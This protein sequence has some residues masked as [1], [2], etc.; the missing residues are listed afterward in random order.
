MRGW[1]KRQAVLLV[2]GLGLLGAPGRA[3]AQAP[4]DGEAPA[5]SP[6]EAPAPLE[7]ETPAPSPDELPAHADGMPQVNPD[8]RGSED[9]AGSIKERAAYCLVMDRHFVSAR[10]LA[11]E[12]L[13]QHPDSFRA[14]FVM[15]YAQHFGEA[16]LP[17]ALFHLEAA[18]RGFVRAWGIEPDKEAS[19]WQ[20]YYRILLELLYV[21][22]EMDHHEAKILYVDRLRERLGISYEARKAWP[23]LKLKRFDEARRIAKKAAESEDEWERAVGLTGLCAVESELRNREAAYEACKDAARRVMRTDSDG[24]VELSNAAAAAEEMFAFDEAERL[25]LQA[26]QR[27]PEGSVNPWGRLVRLYLRQGRLAEAL[28]AWRQM[29]TYRAGRVGAHM[30]QQDQAEAD[31]IGAAVMLVAGRGEDAERITRRT[32]SRPDRQGTSSAASDQNEAGADIMDRVAKQTAARSLEARASIVG[33]GESLKL[34]A[35]AWELRYEAWQSGRRAADV[36]A[37]EERLLSTLRPECPGS[38]ELPSWLDAEVIDLVGPGVA[39]AALKTSRRQETLPEALSEPVFLGFEA[40]A[41]WRR[42]DMERALTLAQEVLRLLPASEALHRARAAAVGAAA[43]AELGQQSQAR[44]LYQVVIAQD[45]AVIRRLG[46]RLPVRL[47]GLGNAQVVADALDLLEGS[48]A[49]DIVDWGLVLQVGLQEVRLVT[50][51]GSVVSSLEVPPRP[52]GKDAPDL[53]EAQWLANSVHEG[54]LAPNLDITQSDVRSLDGSLG[55]GGKASQRVQ[56]ILDEVQAP[57]Q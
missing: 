39:L 37:N 48:P 14:H 52:K 56:D 36:L 55:T 16:N 42:G 5:P 29:R 26:T 46:L 4:R 45:P 22:G 21:H 3:T 7:G 38:I 31:L 8:C 49:F 20:A 10:T 34:H 32:V 11:S 9:F 35:R 43:A 28:S 1:V 12:V 2:L 17:K 27:Q 19:P 50:P 41:Y 23:L 47:V 44:A 40:E 25:Y 53:S 57:A 33:W 6:G 18:E 15:G 54:L 24:A 13:S 30:D 51:D